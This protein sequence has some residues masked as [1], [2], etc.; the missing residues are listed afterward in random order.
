LSDTKIL[1]CGLAPDDLRRLRS[2]GGAGEMLAPIR[3]V[4]AQ[5]FEVE[6]R[7]R[8]VCAIEIAQGPIQ[9]RACPNTV[10]GGLMMKSDGQLHHALEMPPQRPVG[11]HFA[12]DIL[13]NL[14][15]VKK[16]RSVEQIE[17]LFELPV[18]GRHGH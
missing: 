1:S 13:E 11:R 15:R 18:T 17:P 2:G 12:P 7:E 8:A 10:A 14:M 16:E 9:D 5:A 4:S 3:Q 6:I